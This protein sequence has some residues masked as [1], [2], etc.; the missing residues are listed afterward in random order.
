MAA[1]RQLFLQKNS[2]VYI[3]L[4][5]KCLCE[6][7]FTFNISWKNIVYAKLMKVSLVTVPRAC[8]FFKKRLQ[9]ISCAYSK[10]FRDCFYRTNPVDT[11]EVSFSIRKKYIKKES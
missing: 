7:N 5:S 4:G 1:S 8:N 11:F 9:H 6:H 2:I 10:I 3:Q